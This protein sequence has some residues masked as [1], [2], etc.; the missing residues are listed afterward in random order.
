MDSEETTSAIPLQT[1]VYEVDPLPSS[2]PNAHNVQRTTVTP[3]CFPKELWTQCLADIHGRPHSESLRLDVVAS[4]NVGEVEQLSALP[5][6]T[7]CGPPF[8]C[9]CWIAVPSSWIWKAHI[10]MLR[11][12]TLAYW[13]VLG[14]SRKNWSETSLVVVQL[15]IHKA[16]TNMYSISHIHPHFDFRELPN[17]LSF[18][19]DEDVS[20]SS[21]HQTDL[22]LPHLSHATFSLTSFR[23]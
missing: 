14:M 19:V 4:I 11:S 12:N 13:D 7:L 10:A 22:L 20:S 23:V 2:S 17:S 18:W 5:S 15:N 1:A 9:W 3:W 8:V 21:P 6:T 16:G